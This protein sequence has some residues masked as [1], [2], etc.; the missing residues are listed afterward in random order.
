MRCFFKK[1]LKQTLNTQSDFICAKL[2]YSAEYFIYSFEKFL[3][4]LLSSLFFSFLSLTFSNASCIFYRFSYSHGWF[5]FLYAKFY[6]FFLYLKMISARSKRRRI[7]PLVFIL[8]CVSKKLP[9]R[10]PENFSKKNFRA[11]SRSQAA[12]F[13]LTRGFFLGENAHIF[14]EKEHFMRFSTILNDVQFSNC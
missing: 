13:S 5:Y 6:S 2:F 12:N 14:N 7:L 10:T 3:L 1:E 8:K 9:F 4:L 11:F